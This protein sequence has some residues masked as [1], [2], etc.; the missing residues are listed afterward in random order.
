MP[1]EPRLRDRELTSAYTESQW[2]SMTY[3]HRIGKAREW[4]RKA[5]ETE[6]IGG[7]KLIDWIE[8][9]RGAA[10]PAT[11]T[12]GQVP[13]AGNEPTAHGTNESTNATTTSGQ[14]PTA[15]NE[16]PAHETGEN[17]NT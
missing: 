15:G 17:T 5:C 4:L 2:Q 10:L 7:T 16:P 11:T 1:N 12:T 13:A 14:V 3:S 6:L 8:Q 9:R